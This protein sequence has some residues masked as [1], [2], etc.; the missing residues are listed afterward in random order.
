M[1]N[2]NLAATSAPSWRASTAFALLA[3]EL[4]I[5]FIRSVGSRAEK[6]VSGESVSGGMSGEDSHL[7]HN[8][9]ER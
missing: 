1:Q 7:D 4:V 8:R 5:V 9:T 2:Q 6:K 3:N